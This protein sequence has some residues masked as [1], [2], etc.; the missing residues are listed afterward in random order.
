MIVGNRTRHHQ[1]GHGGNDQQ[2]CSNHFGPPCSAATLSGRAT[3][4][5]YTDDFLLS[6]KR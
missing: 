4:Q 5:T 2:P 6:G 1:R 3:G